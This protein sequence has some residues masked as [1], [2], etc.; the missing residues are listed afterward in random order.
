M[1]TIYAIYTMYVKCVRVFYFLRGN[2][3]VWESKRR[4]A[5]RWGTGAAPN[6]IYIL[7]LG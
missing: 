3:F 7:Y 5:G 6:N 2:Y 4:L 1:R